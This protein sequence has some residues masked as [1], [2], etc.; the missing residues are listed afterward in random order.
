MYLVSPYISGGDLS[1]F[2]VAHP[3]SNRSNLVR[4]LLGTLER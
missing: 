4:C 3:E 1:G 2:L